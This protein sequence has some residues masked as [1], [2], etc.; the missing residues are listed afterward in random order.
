LTKTGDVKILDLGLGAFVGVSNE[1]VR[2]TDTDEGFVVGTTDYMSPEQVTGQAVDARTDLFSLG[3]TMYRLLTGMYA[4]PGETKA[5]RLVRR[6][7]LGHV[8][9]AEVRPDLPIRL[10]AFLERLLAASPDDRFSSAVET[11]EALDAMVHF[12]GHTDRGPRFKEAGK[13]VPRPNPPSSPPEPE[14]P[15]DWSLIESELASKADRGRRAQLS[16]T[17]Q[18]P[19]PGIPSTSSGRLNTYRRGLEDEGTESGRS[20]QKQYRQELIQLNRGL[21][22]ERDQEQA[23]EPPSAA[24]TWL[25]RLGEQVGDFLAEPSAGQIIAALV[26]I[27][28]IVAIA[29]AVSLS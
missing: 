22:E 19:S 13:P 4:F 25:E 29:L 7:Q 21:V 20:V 27:T 9:L 28:L 26:I 10:A 15:L 17:K 11:A 12:R 1:E 8:P 2:P 18:T 14:A 16:V 23:N 24:E 5:D 3:C 6:I